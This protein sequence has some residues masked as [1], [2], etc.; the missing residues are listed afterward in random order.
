MIWALCI[1]LRIEVIGSAKLCSD[2]PFPALQAAGVLLANAT[3]SSSAAAAAG[4][5]RDVP[6]RLTKVAVQCLNNAFD[7]R[8]EAEV[9]TETSQQDQ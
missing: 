1:W 7:V 2:A 3:T 9:L 6:S 5:K 8:T 4:P